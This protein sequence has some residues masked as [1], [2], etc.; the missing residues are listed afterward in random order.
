MNK[1]FMYAWVYIPWR[2]SLKLTKLK[3]PIINQG[4]LLI[5]IK[6]CGICGSDLHLF[7]TNI[8][9]RI[10]LR[11]FINNITIN[12]NKN[13]KRILGHEISGIVMGSG[14]KSFSSGDRVAVFP[15]TPLGNIGETLPGGFAEYVVVPSSNALK[16]PS[17]VSYEEG[18]LLEPLGSALHAVKKQQQVLKKRRRKSIN[19]RCWNYRS[20]GYNAH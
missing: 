17:H 9:T 18:A 12:Q 15:K 16:I 14:D 20:Y 5:K 6:A 7:R 2:R 4:E 19:H 13:K 3:V 11:N 1:E 8:P 10:L